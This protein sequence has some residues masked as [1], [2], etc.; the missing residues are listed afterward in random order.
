M[1]DLWDPVK[2]ATLCASCHIGNQKQK[3]FVTHEMYAAGHPP[4]P[5]FEPATFSEEMP[6]HWQYL[7]QKPADVQKLPGFPYDGKEQEQTRL[8]LVGAMVSLRES[9]RLLAQQALECKKKDSNGLALDLANFDC[10][11]CHH[12]LRADKRRRP[13]LAGRPGRPPM[14]PWPLALVKLAIHHAAGNEEIAKKMLSSFEEKVKEVQ[15]AFGAQPF[16]DPGEII[17]TADALAVWADGLVRIL[18]KKKKPCDAAEVRRLLL[19]L[20]TL[21]ERDNLDYDS[22][23]QVAWA[24]K[25]MYQESQAP[26]D[27]MA[28]PWIEKAI[29]SLESQLKL[30]LP[31]GAK[32]KS[33]VPA[34]KDGL[35][36]LNNF[37][38][39]KFKEVLGTLTKREGKPTRR[40][41]L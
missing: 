28:N 10:Y 5:G 26:P 33:V 35:H 22:A 12:D 6:R 38:P 13:A 23:R 15:G 24:L 16:G 17:C 7:R 2:R 1:K 31:T 25:I 20:P 21:Y 18:D 19:L 9:M 3:K 40:E 41:G 27:A 4:L 11:A 32:K 8:L 30:E 29:A 34:L 14:R 36:R 37:D 39:D